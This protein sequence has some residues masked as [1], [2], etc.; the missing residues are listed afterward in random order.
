MSDLISQIDLVAKLIDEFGLDQAQLKGEDWEIKLV[1]SARAK[2]IVQPS[3][4]A[5][6]PTAVSKVARE[7]PTKKS[8][9]PTGIPINSPTTGIFYSSPSPGSPSFVNIGDTVEAGQVIGLI[10]AMKVFNEITAT[11]SGVVKQVAVENGQLVQP[12]DALIYIG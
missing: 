1:R 12:G 4:T 2:V 9:K 8:S 11:V 6:A 5:S 3:S 7:K 10:E